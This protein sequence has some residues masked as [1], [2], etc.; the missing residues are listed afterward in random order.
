MPVQ[1]RV[2]ALR[3]VNEFQAKIRNK[4]IPQQNDCIYKVRGNKIEIMSYNSHSGSSTS[5]SI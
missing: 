3:F 1:R 2:D 4:L 5:F